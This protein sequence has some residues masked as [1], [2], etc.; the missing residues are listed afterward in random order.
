MNKICYS[1]VE[2]LKLLIEK[3]VFLYIQKVSMISIK[4]QWYIEYDFCLRVSPRQ[5][6][7]SRYKFVLSCCLNV[8]YLEQHILF[9]QAPVEN[10][11]KLPKV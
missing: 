3:I 8:H 9:D 6:Q 10:F 1:S 2:S 11:T 4:D 7:P 5:R